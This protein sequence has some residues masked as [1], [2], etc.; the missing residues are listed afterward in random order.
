MEN[1]VSIR[2]AKMRFPDPEEHRTKARKAKIRKCAKIIA[3]III[4]TLPNNVSAQWHSSRGQQQ[5]QGHQ[6]YYG[7][8]GQ[9]GQQGHHDQHL[10]SYNGRLAMGQQQQ[11]PS[12]RSA[13]P[14]QEHLRHFNPYHQPTPAGHIIFRKVGYSSTATKFFTLRVPVRVAAIQQFMSDIVRTIRENLPNLYEEEKANE[15]NAR[16]IIVTDISKLSKIDKWFQ[17]TQEPKSHNINKREIFTASVAFATAAKGFIFGLAGWVA[18]TVFDQLFSPAAI[19]NFDRHADIVDTAV[20]HLDDRSRKTLNATQNAI[21]IKERIVQLVKDGYSAYIQNRAGDFARITTSRIVNDVEDIFQAAL[22]GKAHHK[23][24]RSIDLEKANKDMIRQAAAHNL[25]PA[26]GHY[27]DWL[28]YDATFKARPNRGKGDFDVHL[29]IPFITRNSDYDMYNFVPMPMTLRQGGH[30]FLR[31]GDNLRYIGINSQTNHFR[32]LS[33]TE[34]RDCKLQ[35]AFYICPRGNVARKIPDMS[36]APNPAAPQDPELCILALFREHHLHAEHHCEHRVVPATEMATQISPSQFVI[37]TSQPHSAIMKCTNTSLSYGHRLSVRNTKILDVPPSCHVETKEFILTASDSALEQ[38]AKHWSVNYVWPYNPNSLLARLQ[39]KANSSDPVLMQISLLR[40][41]LQEQAG[42]IHTINVTD[43]DTFKLALEAARRP[44]RQAATWTALI[45]V[46]VSL[47]ALI[48]ITILVFKL[49]PQ[50]MTT[51]ENKVKALATSLNISNP[52]IP[53]AF[54]LD[55]NNMPDTR[56]PTP[57]RSPEQ[58]AQ[59]FAQIIQWAHLQGIP[60]PGTNPWNPHHQGNMVQQ[61]AA[62]HPLDLVG[63][64]GRHRQITQDSRRPLALGYSP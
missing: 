26:Y 63:L 56:T 23:L 59:D 17:P 36:G 25:I 30:I 32:A 24:F 15:Q 31:P 49:R 12:F 58:M 46:P 62:V 38:N 55:N 5:Q 47:L 50:L 18:T 57:A 61:P 41:A 1:N 44:Q 2:R 54:H 22:E 20:T 21:Y 28:Q 48:G 40:H 19:E 60:I 42:Y 3:F 10:H 6:S 51:I 33:E 52:R 14:V 43:P 27:S 8:Q 29:H 53:D 9:H 45:G 13:P 4:A 16:S 35:G 64:N 34:F 37:F 7:F 39:A 11:H